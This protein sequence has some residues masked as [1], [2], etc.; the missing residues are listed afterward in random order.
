M[1]SMN[2]K[3]PVASVIHK[4]KERL[5]EAEAIEQE[6]EKIKN[7]AAANREKFNAALLKLV[8]G[9]TPVEVTLGN[10]GIAAGITTVSVRYEVP[11]AKIPVR[12]ST[13]EFKR[14]PW[15][16]SELKNAISIL[17]MT[18]DTHVNASTFK[19]ISKYL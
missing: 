15:S 2:V 16:I 17:E 18:D 4:L 9:E 13:A 14:Q 19:H 1:P 5:K 7:A 11:R 10:W 6:N 8:E 3:I 12:K